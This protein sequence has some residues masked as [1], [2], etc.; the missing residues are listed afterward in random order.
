MKAAVLTVSDGVASGVRKDLS[1]AAIVDFLKDNG[2]EVV[3]AKTVADEQPL[4][5]AV[6]VT[7]CETA[8]LVV[9]TG[10]TGIAARD[11]TPEATIAVCDQVIP[12]LAELMR[13]EGLKQTHFAVLSRAVCGSRG[14]SLIVNL[15]GSPKGAL[16]SLAIV[17]PLVA[18][19]L[20][21]LAGK[22][23]H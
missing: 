9:T 15:P 11:V 5:E 12:G 3:A 4:I 18:H 6:L 10:G 16:Q 2:C 13:A 17:F 19:A 21:L 8:R 22:T 1:G 20:D 23:E 7:M 14:E